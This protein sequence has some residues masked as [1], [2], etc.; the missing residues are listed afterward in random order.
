MSK[1]KKWSSFKEH[2]KLTEN[3]RK[4][5]KGKLTEFEGDPLPIPAPEDQWGSDET[6]E[7]EYEPPRVT[8]TKEGRAAELWVFYLYTAVYAK[9]KSPS[10]INIIRLAS[11]K[12]IGDFESF[13][14]FADRSKLMELGD[15]QA[16]EKFNMKRDSFHGRKEFD[17]IGIERK[18]GGNGEGP[19]ESSLPLA[20]RWYALGRSGK[21]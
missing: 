10:L 20:K 4:W 19:V 3:F 5:S 9:R 1:N 11:R 13:M 2:Q 16:I 14:E 18:F 21:K 17:S 7:I 15:R 12:G 8:L 6:E